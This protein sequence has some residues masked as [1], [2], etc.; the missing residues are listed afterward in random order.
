MLSNGARVST[1]VRE[2]QSGR[3]RKTKA[4]DEHI[5][6]QRIFQKQ[7]RKIALLKLDHGKQEI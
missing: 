6:R 4:T 5:K 7:E 2:T 3:E 1:G